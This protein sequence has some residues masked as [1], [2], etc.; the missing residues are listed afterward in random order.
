LA[1]NKMLVFF[2]LFILLQSSCRFIKKVAV[3]LF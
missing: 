3:A 2:H 1:I